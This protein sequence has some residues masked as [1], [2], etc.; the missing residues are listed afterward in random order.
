MG[1]AL[2]FGLTDRARAED[3]LFVTVPLG[4]LA[5][6]APLS[7]S[8]TARISRARQ[9]ACAVRPLN[10]SR[11]LCSPSLILQVLS[12]HRLA[13]PVADQR[14]DRFVLAD[15]RALGPDQDR[16]AQ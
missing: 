9:G 1:W 3:T 15:Q 8:G 5:P 10:D 11:S 14:A 13:Q 12:Q 2:N 7:P 4:V 6:S 16:G